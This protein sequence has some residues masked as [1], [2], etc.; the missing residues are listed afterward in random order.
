[1]SLLTN[2]NRLKF[3]DLDI[4]NVLLHVARQNRGFVLGVD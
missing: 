4:A 3:D 1:M 2:K